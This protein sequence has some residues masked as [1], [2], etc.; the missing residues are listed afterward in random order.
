MHE[1]FLTQLGKL[2][3]DKGNNL[4]YIGVGLLYVLILS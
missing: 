4:L 3:V 2:L 1:P